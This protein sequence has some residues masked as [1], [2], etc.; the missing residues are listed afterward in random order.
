MATQA[1]TDVGVMAMV[2]CCS[3]FL[4]AVQAAVLLVACSGDEKGRDLS[5][6]RSVTGS[7]IDFARSPS[8]GT[9]ESL[10][11][12][13]VVH[14]G[15]ADRLLVKRSAE[16]LREPDRWKLPA[17]LFRGRSATYSALELIANEEEFRESEGPHGHC[18]SAPI[19]SPEPVAR[20][21]R[22]SVQPAA[23]D[24][25]LDWWTVDAFVN[26][27]GEIEAITLDLWEP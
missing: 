16:E 27:D 1:R 10:P 17:S 11:L 9:W 20:L 15:L 12:A 6:A 3:L 7:L 5:R 23:P 19:A 26:D 13:D 4:A 24:G 14:L 8:D 22:V 18:A 2:K 25:C 21:R